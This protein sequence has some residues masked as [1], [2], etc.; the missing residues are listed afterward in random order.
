MV[1]LYINDDVIGL[2]RVEEIDIAPGGYWGMQ[3]MEA[4]VPEPQFLGT[5]AFYAWDKELC[6]RTT[7][8]ESTDWVIVFPD[9]AFGVINIANA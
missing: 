5:W 3:L 8:F 6:C 1:T 9:D 2:T 4:L 7:R